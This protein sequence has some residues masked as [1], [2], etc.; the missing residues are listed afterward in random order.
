VETTTGYRRGPTKCKV[1]KIGQG[2]CNTAQK[3]VDNLAEV[4]N[5]EH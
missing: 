4:F 3:P 2:V 5:F 1:I